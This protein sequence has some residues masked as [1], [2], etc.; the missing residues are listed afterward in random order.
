MISFVDTK[1]K[2]KEYF[3][4]I[5]VVKSSFFPVNNG[6]MIPSFIK[7]SADIHT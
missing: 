3:P 5:K 2:T 6:Q 4:N 7:L 1:T